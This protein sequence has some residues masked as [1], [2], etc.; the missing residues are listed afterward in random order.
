MKKIIISLLIFTTTLSV[1]AQVNTNRVM[2]IGKNALYF[3]DYVLAIQYFNQVVTAK[4]YLADPYYYRAMAK[5]MLDDFKGAEE[6][7]ELCLERNPY[8][9]AAY[10]LRGA[11]RQ[12]Q[13]KFEEAAS[14]YKRSLEFFPE[15][16]L[17]LV[18]MGI[19]NVEMK[20]Y[21]IADKFF[22]V[23]LRRF[24]DYSPGYLTRAQ[25]Y[26]EKEDTVKALQ[27]IEKAIEVDPY[28]AQ[29]FSARGLIYLQQ[30]EYNKALADLDEAI[31]LDP[32]FE[33]NYINRGLV[34]YN[35]NDLRGAM[36]DY[37]RVIEMDGDNL[38]AR[39]NRG[40]LRAQVAD[41]NRAIKDFDKI[42][43]IEPTN[44][45]A[46]LNRAMLHN[47]IGN[48]TEAIHDLNRVL[49]EYPDF[50]SGYYMRADLK[51]QLNDMRG[52]EKDYLIARN[53]EAKARKKATV[54]AED[55][56]KI[57]K[58]SNSKDT[59]EQTDNDIE[60][61]NLLVIADKKTTEQNKNKYQRETRGKVQDRNTQITLEP[62]FV[63][64]YYEKR[65]DVRRPVYYSE[66]L[67]KANRI[68]NLKWTMKMANNEAP[69]NELQVKNHFQSIENY[70]KLIAQNPNN[71]SL[72]FGR[73]IDFVLLQDYENALKDLNK[74]IDLNPK[75]TNAYF[76]RAVIRTKQLELDPI[77]PETIKTEFT[78]VTTVSQ[79]SLP[80]KSSVALPE[81]STKSQLYDEIKRDYDKII[82]I[83][84]TDFFAYYNR[85]E[86][87]YIEKDFRA[88]IADYNKAIELQ[89]DFAEAFFNRGISRLSIGETTPG[90]DDLRKAGELGIVQSYSIIKRMQ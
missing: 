68:L 81:I 17:T 50:F 8:Y 37:D 22:E 61:F 9:I 58:K 7:A 25:M 82:E 20:E 85:A 43:E 46:Y 90:L 87:F 32:Y 6:D 51:R 15:D 11:S 52:A 23:L 75:N 40:L 27:Y 39:F 67:E 12:N 24:P 55:G 4:P 16:K 60:K 13:D 57:A 47:E 14:D 49:E 53:E 88:A 19:V 69:L 64:T 56:R 41:N 62:K 78:E 26:M 45:I 77:E 38:I 72:Y 18:N 89:P 76:V 74:V 86:I 79:T 59:R 35:L 44:T 21:D 63:L 42:I 83:N 66:S 34:K 31:R 71:E 5:F 70:S 48:T 10:Q 65:L 2:T 30:K 84:N 29:S 28:T 36:A 33:G 73:G 54:D 80:K 1:T 3:E